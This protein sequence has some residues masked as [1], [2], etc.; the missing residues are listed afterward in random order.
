MSFSLLS[1][2]ILKLYLCIWSSQLDDHHQP[3]SIFSAILHCQRNKS[4]LFNRQRGKG[5][6]LQ[7]TFTSLGQLGVASLLLADMY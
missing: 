3:L 5:H 7:L 1:Q 6:L 4:L 2:L